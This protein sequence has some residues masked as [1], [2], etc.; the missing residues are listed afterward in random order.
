[1]ELERKRYDVELLEMALGTV[2]MGKDVY[3][4]FI[5]AKMKELKIPAEEKEANEEEELA[6]M[7][8]LEEK[9]WSTFHRDEEGLFLY[10]Y[11]I[12]GF[13]KEAIGTLIEIKKLTATAF[14]AYKKWTDRLVFIEPRR[15]HFGKMVPD[16]T[17]ERSIRFM[18]K[19][20]PRIALKRSDYVNAGTRFSFT[21][22]L[23]AGG[24][25]T[26]EV[27]NMC[28]EYGELVG[29]GEWRGSGGFGAFR[30]LSPKEQTPTVVKKR[31]V[32]AKVMSGIPK[33]R[34]GNVG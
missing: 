3:A 27:I 32:K 13:I 5:L 17:L 33:N 7:V 8:D 12:K 34:S 14:K 11:Q 26:M 6:T 22:A 23:L 1:M 20:G 25:I 15:I 30:I 9:G 21:V 19:D 16:G 2:P 29:V 28:M 24:R 31:K 4:K 10:N 18:T